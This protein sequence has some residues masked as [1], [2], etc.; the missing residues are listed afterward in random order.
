MLRRQIAE[1]SQTQRWTQAYL[2]LVRGLHLPDHSDFQ[3]AVVLQLRPGQAS[4]L[5]QANAAPAFRLLHNEFTDAGLMTLLIALLALPCILSHTTYVH[6]FVQ[7][8]R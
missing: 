2:L 5:R 6:F 8:L 3:P 7:A 4:D 1:Q